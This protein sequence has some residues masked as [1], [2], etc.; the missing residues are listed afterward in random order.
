MSD[1]DTRRE[2]DRE[3]EQTEFFVGSVRVHDGGRIT[4]PAHQRDHHDLDHRDVVDIYIERG[5]DEAPRDLV[6]NDLVLDAEGGV[7][8][9]ERKRI[10]YGIEDDD[11]LD[12]Y[13]RPTGMTMP[14][15]EE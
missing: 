2:T 4:I 14:E 8:P 10:L 13:V 1:S 5:E 15:D 7:R 3:D 9:P 6:A 12:V 11:R